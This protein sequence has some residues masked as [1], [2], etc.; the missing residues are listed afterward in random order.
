M[1]DHL[2]IKD[3]IDPETKEFAQ[4]TEVDNLQRDLRASLKEND[5]DAS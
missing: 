3:A 4:E 2:G 5:P 1:S